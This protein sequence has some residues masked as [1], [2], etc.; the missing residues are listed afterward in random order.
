MSTSP[1]PLRNTGRDVTTAARRVTRRCRRRTG[2][3][4]RPPRGA[5]RPRCTLAVGGQAFHRAA[6]DET[7]FGVTISTPG[8]MRSS[9]SWMSFGCPHGPRRPRPSSTRCLGQA[10]VPS[11]RRGVDRV[12][13]VEAGSR[14]GQSASEASARPGSQSPE[15]AVGRSRTPTPAPIGVRQRPHR[16]P[17][18]AASGTAKPTCCVVSHHT[19][20]AGVVAVAA[21]RRRAA[22]RPAP[23]RASQDEHP[24]FPT[25][26]S[27]PSSLVE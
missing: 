27:S 9:Q 2:G 25:S 23:E 5:A 3:R 8:W 16:P 12:G 13:C 24:S 18:L 26:T 7:R 21:A 22:R 1:V 6:P 20:A 11:H 10:G 19:A 14:G 4:P 17:L 15:S